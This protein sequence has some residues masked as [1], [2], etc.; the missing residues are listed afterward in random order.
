MPD[1]GA[2]AAK[3]PRAWTTQGGSGQAAPVSRRGGRARADRPLCESS[4]IYPCKFLLLDWSLLLIPAW[5][6]IPYR[7]TMIRRADGA[8]F[9]LRSRLERRRRGVLAGGRSRATLGRA[10]G[11]T[12]DR[13][14]PRLRPGWILPELLGLACDRNALAARCL[15][16][17]RRAHRRRLPRRLAGRRIRRVH[18]LGRP[19]NHLVGFD[20]KVGPGVGARSALPG[21]ARHSAR[22]R[23]TERGPVARGRRGYSHRSR[24]PVQPQHQTVP[25][26]PGRLRL[27]LR[28]PPLRADR[29]LER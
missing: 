14:A 25:G 1:A 24:R 22:A 6:G 10:A 12:S 18:R 26:P 13:R 20:D 9:F 27:V 19:F 29:L 4:K 17:S 8:W 7:L 5:V 15:A 2:V 16:G 11:R 21:R 3:Q 23:A 28:L